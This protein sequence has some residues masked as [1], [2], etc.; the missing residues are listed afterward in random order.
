MIRGILGVGVEPG[1]LVRL[2][3]A[4]LVSAVAIF[5]GLISPVPGLADHP[6]GSFAPFKWACP[7][8]A[9]P[10]DDFADVPETNPH[11]PA[12][13]CA[14]WRGLVSG[15]GPGTYGPD[16]SVSRGQM[17]TLAVKLLDLAN[18]LAGD[19]PDAF[20]DDSGGVHERA[21]NLL[22]AAGI[23]AGTGPRQFSP[24]APVSRE[25][26][27]TYLVRVYEHVRRVELPPARDHFQ[28]DDGRV[29]EQAINIAASMG[30]ASGVSATRFE[31]GASI[32]RDQMARLLTAASGCIRP[33]FYDGAWHPWFCDSYPDSEGQQALQGFEVSVTT[34]HSTYELGQPV[35]VGVRACNRRSTPLMQVFPQ[36]DW[37]VLEVRDAHASYSVGIQERQW[38]DHRWEPTLNRSGYAE[39]SMDP[40]NDRIF[41]RDPKLVAVTWYDGPQPSAQDV[42]VWEP[43]ECKDLAVGAWQQAPL[44]WFT[45]PDDFLA[46][47]QRRSETLDGRVSPGKKALHL[48][49]GGVEVGQTRRYLVAD[50]EP[51]NLEGP[52][53]FVTLG[54]ERY[55]PE[56]PVDVTLHAC[57]DSEHLYREEFGPNRFLLLR[58]FVEGQL[59]PRHEIGSLPAEDQ[60]LEWAAGECKSWP[61][62]WDGAFDTQRRLR[63]EQVQFSVEW[64]PS[65]DAA[66]QREQHVRWPWRYLL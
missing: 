50:A 64:H 27:A 51:I 54:K 2:R 55:E 1:V 52:R 22:A 28:D 42:V 29:H 41:N 36:R 8:D 6:A 13:D 11:E 7:D 3:P 35:D 43:G 9:V 10:E 53:L 56:E 46:Q 37:F 59:H 40:I 33:V 21:A 24:S 23:V 15:T 34:D 30:L 18:G 47:W 31:P 25:Q 57:N 61:F 32:R 60:Q 20:D 14:V 65:D 48:S 16:A 26:V 12:V 66:P 63:D 49:W 19:A 17:A 44:G 4:V 62:T 45:E 39:R 38:Y 58:L 5:A